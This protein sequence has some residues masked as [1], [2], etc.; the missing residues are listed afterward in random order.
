MG[1]D[2]GADDLSIHAT[3]ANAGD[4]DKPQEVGHYVHDL[5]NPGYL[6]VKAFVRGYTESSH[7]DRSFMNFKKTQ[8]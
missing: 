6:F 3:G 4:Y 8:L 5:P 1:E 2:G 7:E